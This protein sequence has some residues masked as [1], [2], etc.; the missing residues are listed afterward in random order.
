MLCFRDRQPN[1]LSLSGLER[2]ILEVRGLERE[3]LRG[4]ERERERERD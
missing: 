4:L 1:K 3:R 2:E